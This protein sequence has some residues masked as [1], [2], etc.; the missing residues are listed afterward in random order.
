MNVTFSY[1]V[2]RLD[3]LNGFR[4]TS[5][6]IREDGVVYHYHT[7]VMRARDAAERTITVSGNGGV[8]KA[9]FRGPITTEDLERQIPEPERLLF[10]EFL[11]VLARALNL[12]LYERTEGRGRVSCFESPEGLMVSGVNEGGARTL[13]YR[14]ERIFFEEFLPAAGV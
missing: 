14:E 8:P 10:I 2:D 13:T 9:F 7:V 11:L 5:A 1:T 3:E 12:A 6:V 4:I